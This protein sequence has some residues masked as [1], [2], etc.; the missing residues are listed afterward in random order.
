MSGRPNRI[1]TRRPYSRPCFATAPGSECSRLEERVRL[2]LGSASC[3]MAGE[4]RIRRPWRAKT[5]RANGRIR[6]ERQQLSVAAGTMPGHHHD[7]ERL[8][9]TWDVGPF[10]KDTAAEF[11]GDL[12]QA[13]AVDRGGPHPEHFRPRHR[14]L[15]LPEPPTTNAARRPASRLS[16]M[17]A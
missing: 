17:T 2:A 9:G 1:F 14:H 10:D 3:R 12:D 16:V 7:Q 5:S 6:R 15:R 11:S 4:L 8:T 13:P